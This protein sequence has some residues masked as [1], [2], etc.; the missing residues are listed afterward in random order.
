MEFKI[1]PTQSDRIENISHVLLQLP[2]GVTEEPQSD[3][4]AHLGTFRG[5]QAL[6]EAYIAQS[7]DAGQFLE[8]TALEAEVRQLVATAIDPEA[9]DEGAVQELLDRHKDVLNRYIPLVNVRETIS[10]GILCRA[11]IQYGLLFNNTKVAL[12]ALPRR[13]SWIQWINDNIRGIKPRTAQEY[14]ALADYPKI[15]KYSIFG[16]KRLTAI[17]MHLPKAETFSPTDDPVGDWLSENDIVFNA[18]EDQ[19]PETQARQVDKAIQRA[20]LREQNIEGYREEVLEVIVEKQKSVKPHLDKL[21]AFME[22]GGDVN[23][24]LQKFVIDGCRAST[25]QT[26]QDPASYFNNTIKK[27]LEDTKEMVGSADFLSKI[28][29]GVI[30]ELKALLAAVEANGRTSEG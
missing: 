25:E 20:M 6:T 2:E 18:E 5:N 12:K 4:Q 23:T 28:D 10:N 21:K 9:L 11:K 19:A 15:I 22:G 27:V 14:M 29:Q 17:T 3:D 26:D 1:D 30:G 13:T 7:D 24:G 16:I 8:D